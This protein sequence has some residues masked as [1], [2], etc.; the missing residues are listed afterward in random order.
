MRKCDI[1]GFFIEI[2][3]KIRVCMRSTGEVDK[4]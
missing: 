2:D 4:K 1:L 3:L